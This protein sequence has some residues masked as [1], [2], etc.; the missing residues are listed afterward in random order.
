MRRTAQ[1]SPI[2]V[3]N[4]HKNNHLYAVGIWR[5]RLE[6]IVYCLVKVARPWNYTTSYALK[7]EKSARL[8]VRETIKAAFLAGEVLK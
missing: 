4:L 2:T 8:F 1:A 7:P 6:I 3:R 5:L